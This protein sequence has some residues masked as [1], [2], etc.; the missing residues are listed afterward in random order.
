MKDVIAESTAYRVTV[1]GQMRYQ[2]IIGFGGAFTDAAGIN[3]NALSEKAHDALL[4]A[5]FGP[6]GT[7]D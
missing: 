1:D 5:Y 6:K 3:M 7:P 4:E 2:K